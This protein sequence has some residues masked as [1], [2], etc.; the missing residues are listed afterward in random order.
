MGGTLG[1]GVNT[2]VFWIRARLS[3]GRN[4]IHNLGFSPCAYSPLWIRRTGAKALRGPIC[5]GTTEVVP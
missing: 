4:P 2:P 5:Y 1:F 3:S